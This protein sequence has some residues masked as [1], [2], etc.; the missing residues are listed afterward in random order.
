[1]ATPTPRITGQSPAVSL[2]GIPLPPAGSS[3]L[4]RRLG[5]LMVGRTVVISVVLGLNVWLLVRGEVRASAAVWVMS[6]LIA[7]TYA[8]TIVSGLLIR[9]GVAPARLVWPQLA[10]DLAVTAV[11]VLVTG[12]AQS[13][14]TFFFALSVVGGGALAYRRGVVVVGLA[15]LLLLVGVALLAWQDASPLPTVPQVRPAAQS[16]ADF[17]RSLAQNAAAIAAIGVLSYVFGDQ[18]EKA[19]QS[20]ATE[21]RTVADLV[22][23]HRDIVRSLSSGLVTIDLDNRV[24]TANEVAG[25]ILGV[26]PDEL[27]GKSVDAALPGL[28]ARLAVAMTLRRADLEIARTGRPDLALGVSVSP[29]RDDTD[30]VVGRVINFQDLTELRK[31][32]HKMRRAERLASIGQLAAGIAHEIRNP[33]ASISGS[34]ELLRQAPQVTDDD[35]AL[36]AI[37]TREI[38]RLDALISDVLEFTNP[39]PRQVVRV[40]L[41]VLVDETLAVFRQ[42][43]TVGAVAIAV[44]REPGELGLDAD[45]GKLRQVL[46]NLLRNA[47]E[48]VTAPGGG[49][50]GTIEVRVGRDGD[51]AVIEVADDGPGIPADVLPR[52]FDPFF[53]TKRKGTGLGLATCYSI[54][55]EHG[56]SIEAEPRAPHGTRFVVRLPLAS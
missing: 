10:T 36:M 52:I 29:L 43:P 38:E 37:V 4:G 34:I 54:V 22:S 18:L 49:G 11:L 16:Q 46:W 31:M 32:E 3:D 2:V 28:G 45:P 41:G 13:A 40:D 42:D 55:D 44:E 9:A 15:S 47:A 6:A 8:I 26:A 53:S 27:V 19:T 50:G 24:L 39:R 7:A 12:G 1:V 21:R 17:L 35:K 14:F 33:L 51:R 23:L 30:G 48:A 5:W 25:D 20:L 56:G